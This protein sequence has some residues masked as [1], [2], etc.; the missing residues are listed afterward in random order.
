M[1]GGGEER[2]RRRG[3]AVQD[4]KAPR[5]GS[6]SFPPNQEE[7]LA[8]QTPARQKSARDVVQDAERAG[9]AL[10]R[11]GS[12]ANFGGCEFGLKSAGKGQKTKQSAAEE[13]CRGT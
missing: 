9:E 8:C 3:G 7:E 12:A 6:Q 13:D 1:E 4:A 11:T 2:K 5:D 10:L